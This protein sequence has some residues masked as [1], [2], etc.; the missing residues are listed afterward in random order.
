MLESTQYPFLSQTIRLYDYSYLFKRKEESYKNLDGLSEEWDLQDQNSSEVGLG[1]SFTEQKDNS[2]ESEHNLEAVRYLFNTKDTTKTA[3]EDNSEYDLEG[4]RDLFD[5]EDTTKTGSSGKKD[6]TESDSSEHKG[7]F[8]DKLAEIFS[9][10]KEDKPSGSEVESSNANNS[11]KPKSSNP[12]KTLDSSENIQPIIRQITK[13]EVVFG[14]IQ[15]IDSKARKGVF[16]RGGLLFYVSK[17]NK[18]PFPN[19]RKLRHYLIFTENGTKIPKNFKALLQMLETFYRNLRSGQYEKEIQFYEGMSEEPNVLYPY[20]DFQLAYC[21]RLIS[22]LGIRQLN[23]L[24]ENSLQQ[25]FSTEKHE[26]ELKHKSEDIVCKFYQ[27]TFKTEKK[28]ESSRSL[29]HIQYD[30]FELPTWREEFMHRLQIV[31]NIGLTKE[32][33]ES[34]RKTKA[35]QDH[36][37][38]LVTTMGPFGKLV[39]FRVTDIQQ[40]RKTL[41]EELPKLQDENILLL[42]PT[43]VGLG[44][45]FPEVKTFVK[46]FDIPTDETLNLDTLR[47]LCQTM[48]DAYKNK[49]TVVCAVDE[50]NHL[51]VGEDSKYT[52]E[53]TLFI[54]NILEKI[55][56]NS[57]IPVLPEKK[58]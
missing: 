19:I 9:Q 26:Y 29:V 42:N 8:K 21:Y 48:F 44:V 57:W 11:T 15:P 10:R 43:T 55:F 5:T 56:Y 51:F 25:Q 31:K 20:E 54:V 50:E 12:Q 36:I 7:K 52:V 1:D 38:K 2:P 49:L 13:N 17:K 37:L 14:N 33:K 16:G 4:I 22:Q 46:T 35:F 40:L 30:T 24:N 39:R 32:M 34:L 23:G 18:S 53:D 6:S 58:Q 47:N 41:H 45:G 27:L 28:V 3:K